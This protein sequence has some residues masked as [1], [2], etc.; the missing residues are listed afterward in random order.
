M[1]DNTGKVWSDSCKGAISIHG[2]YKEMKSKIFVL[3]LTHTGKNSL[4]AVL[5]GFGYTCKHYPN[6][7]HVLEEAEKYDVLSDIPVILF[8]EELD[9]L[10]PDAKFILTVR[11]IESWLDSTRIHFKTKPHISELQKW[12]RQQIY[13]TATYDREIFRKAYRAHKARVLK[14]FADR[15]DKLL[16]FN[17][18]GGE[19]YEILC[20]FIGE[21]I[22]K[23]TF[24]H[25]NGG[26]G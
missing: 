13:G 16:V 3:G 6:P 18:C 5:R 12:T 25:A 9:K 22:L 14:Y 11:E 23:G 15:P 24:P 20:P 10:Y 8:M 26:R 17:I 19:G 2:T 7:K 1:G 4:D 21:P